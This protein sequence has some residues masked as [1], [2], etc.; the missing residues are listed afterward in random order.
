MQHPSI[1]NWSPGQNI[2]AEGQRY[3]RNEEVGR[4]N[5]QL[6]KLPQN[7]VKAIL[8]HLDLKDLY[9]AGS[10]CRTFRDSEIFRE[11][12]LKHL[13]HRSQNTSQV[14]SVIE[15]HG[16][17]FSVLREINFPENSLL[18]APIAQSLTAATLLEKLT[19]AGNFIPGQNLAVASAVSKL[20]GLKAMEIGAWSGNSSTSG[21]VDLMSKKK[22]Q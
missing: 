9:S 15:R 6:D 17:D 11:V 14:S 22:N 21:L 7:I 4:G 18:H 5:Q 2:S 10:S 8:E 13:L 12:N 16:K 1:H 19:I 20:Y 3:L